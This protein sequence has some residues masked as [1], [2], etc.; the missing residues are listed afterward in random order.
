MTAEEW[1]ALAKQTGISAKKTR[2]AAWAI[3]TYPEEEN[4]KIAGRTGVAVS[5][6]AMIREAIERK[7]IELGRDYVPEET[8]LDFWDQRAKSREEKLALENRP[9]ANRNFDQFYATEETAARRA[10]ILDFYEDLEGKRI[11]FLGDDD[12]GS[13]RAAALKKAKSI[14][15]ADI[16][17]RLLQYIDA[18]AE[19]NQL[20]IETEKYDARKKL[21]EKLKGKFDTVFTDPPYT[22]RGVQLFLSRAIE[23]LDSQNPTARIYL[24]FG[25]SDRAKERFMPIYETIINSGLMIRRVWDKINRYTGAESIGSTSSLY[26][27]EITPKTKPIIKGEEN[28]PIYTNN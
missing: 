1:L 15:A 25:N 8:E 27:L 10:E 7:Q 14:A 6:V 2:D 21:P 22:P 4:K 18:L 26:Q 24:C 28:E 16:D 3:K 12:L 23:A 5:A 19:K 20:Q 9:M 17:N 13:V 11:L